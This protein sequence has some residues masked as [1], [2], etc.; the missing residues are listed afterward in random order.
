MHINI[1]SSSQ[2]TFSIH[3]I[4]DQ[5][6][7]SIRQARKRS[8]SQSSVR[9]R[10]SSRDGSKQDTSKDTDKSKRQ[11]SERGQRHEQ[12]EY[13]NI[14][15]LD[16][17]MEK[18]KKQKEK[19]D[20]S[21][22]KRSSREDR[23]SQ[24]RMPS[25]SA[26]G[27]PPGWQKKTIGP[28]AWY[29]DD[30]NYDKAVF[31]DDPFMNQQYGQLLDI[32]YREQMNEIVNP[33]SAFVVKDAISK[34]YPDESGY[35]SMKTRQ[36]KESVTVSSKTVTERSTVSK[37]K[38]K[39]GPRR[40]LKDDGRSQTWHTLPGLGTKF[41]ELHLLD[42]Q[43]KQVLLNVSHS[44][45]SNK[46]DGETG[47]EK[48]TRRKSTS[49]KPQARQDDEDKV[50]WSPAKA[51][52]QM[53]RVKEAP[54]KN[55]VQDRMKAFQNKNHRDASEVSSAVET[56]AL[57][58][59]EEARQK[60]FGMSKNYT[61]DEPSSII[62]DL[63]TTPNP[64]LQQQQK[65]HREIVRD[66]ALSDSKDSG[67][68][69]ILSDDQ[70]DQKAEGERKRSVKELLSDFEEKSRLLAKQE[71]S[72]LKDDLAQNHEASTRRRVFSDTE[73][74]LYDSS[75]DDE[76]DESFKNTLYKRSIS[77][78]E[79]KMIGNVSTQSSTT[80]M[81]GSSNDKILEFKRTIEQTVN[82]PSYNFN[83]ANES[84]K[85][86][87]KNPINQEDQ[88]ITMTP[89]VKRSLSE[90]PYLKMSASI[91]G[92]TSKDP[93]HGSPSRGI[94]ESQ[95]LSLTHSQ[96]SLT[97]SS[98]SRGS[99]QSISNENVLGVTRLRDSTPTEAA[100]GSSASG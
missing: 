78:T 31:V 97:S 8:K 99:N 87:G 40:R 39:D 24:P 84:P 38:G 60:F 22:R 13:I 73:T 21:S 75:T 82:N 85:D 2:N 4:L 32:H 6:E 71:E 52:E 98:H 67:S 96:N 91:L 100:I 53:R 77:T 16:E 44:N 46:K 26:D 18:Y 81:S 58:S 69:N 7:A 23:D 19:E 37:A 41:E 83:Q 68:D 93:L 35:G 72:D 42:K 64:S 30:F 20:S 36:L 86:F 80:E 62:S 95:A 70:L 25:T 15:A 43:G 63:T 48:R 94:I 5:D 11:S 14:S 79:A 51:F 27:N 90:D 10:T 56:S 59:K 34:R 12:P 54:P 47:K 33:P 76:D 28:D 55:L 65:K 1:N 9:S 3:N 92:K 61:S 66:F 57:F 74:M 88:Y 89:P 29:N 50:P 45:D 17:S 49:S